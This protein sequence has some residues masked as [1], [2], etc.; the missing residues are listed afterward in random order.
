MAV[1]DFSASSCNDSK[2]FSNS[3]FNLLTTYTFL[4]CIVLY[5]S[6]YI[7]PLN[8]HRQTEALLDT[9]PVLIHS[10]ESLVGGEQ[11][12]M[13]TYMYSA[14]IQSDPIGRI[15]LIQPRYRLLI[16]SDRLSSPVLPLFG[17][18]RKILEFFIRPWTFL[19][20]LSF[21]LLC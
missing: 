8:S 9:S 17:F 14:S 13:R 2:V 16:L 15:R 21:F 19:K 5:S 4:Y 1:I 18:S 10:P 11:L 3:L 12:C 6:I 7:A 20:T